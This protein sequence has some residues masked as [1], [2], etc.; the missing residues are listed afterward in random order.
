MASTW[1]VVREP[2]ASGASYEFSGA[3]PGVA[4]RIDQAGQ[5]TTAAN[6]YVLFVAPQIYNFGRTQTLG[7]GHIAMVSAK[8][9]EAQVSTAGQLISY[10]VTSGVN[11]SRL[12]N[13]GSSIT[14]GGIIT[15][16][17]RSADNLVSASSV[18]QRGT[19]DAGNFN[20]DGGK[21]ILEADNVSLAGLSQTLAGGTTRGGYVEVLSR[22]ASIKG[23]I[24]TTGSQDSSIYIVGLNSVSG[25]GASLVAN[26]TLGSGGQIKVVSQRTIDFEDSNLIAQG[27]T[28]GGFIRLISESTATVHGGIEAATL[29]LVNVTHHFNPT[30]PPTG[31]P[32]GTSQVLIQG[33]SSLWSNGRTGI[34]GRV[35]VTGDDIQI[36][37]TTNIYAIGDLG[38]GQ[39]RIGGDWQGGSDVSLR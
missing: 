6:G 9:V 32:A 1:E 18:E 19:L 16:S 12:V 21:I 29:G 28:D 2:N 13:T 5:L 7:A 26:S 31:P 17:A 34:G 33:A 36:S 37:G 15:M 4:G 11:D 24:N 30:G 3:G 8:E 20:G 27:E 25:L 22:S 38:G 14:Q 10:Q 39:I 23:G 35:A